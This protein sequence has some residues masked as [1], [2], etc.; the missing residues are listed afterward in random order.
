MYEITARYYPHLPE[1]ARHIGEAE[2]RTKLLEL[3]FHSVGAAQTKDVNKMFRWGTG[4]T[5]RKIGRL[6][7][8]GKIVEEVT[9]SDQDGNWLALRTVISGQ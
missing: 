2:A 3:Y 1:Q 5:A 9:R 7:E 8:A 6:V 4:L